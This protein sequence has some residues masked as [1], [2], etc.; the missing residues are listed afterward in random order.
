MAFA[1]VAPAG[2]TDFSAFGAYWDTDAAGDAGGG[3]LSLGLPFNETVAAEFRGSY[4]EEL[5]DDPLSNAF[6]SDDPVFQEVGVN[7]APLDAGLRLSFLPDAAFKPYVSGG[8]SYFLLDSDFGEVDDELGYYASVGA[9]MGHDDGAQFFIEGLWRKATAEV[10]LDPDAL[11]DV[12]D[13][14]VEDRADLDID[15]L[16]VNLGVRWGFS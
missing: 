11:D 12:D 3:G 13:I 16:G 6:D 7:V 4:Y 10:R 15:G 2:A 9:T 1:I 14:D 8:A 5:S